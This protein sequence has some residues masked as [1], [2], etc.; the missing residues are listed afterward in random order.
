MIITSNGCKKDDDDSGLQSA[1]NYVTKGTNVNTVQNYTFNIDSIQ[2]EKDTANKQWSAVYT[3]PASANV[4]GAVVLYVQDDSNW[5]AL[6]HV[7]YGITTEF[8]F[9]P[10]TKVVEVQAADAKAAILIPNPGAMSFKLITIPPALKKANP[11]LNFTNYKDVEK[12][13]NL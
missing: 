4:S 8:G 12:V 7:D 1:G 3:L 11:D 10:V 5:A 2:W 9:N 13:F 6:P